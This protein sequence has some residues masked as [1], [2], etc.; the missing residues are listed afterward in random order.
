MGHAYNGPKSDSWSNK[1]TDL[2]Q[3]VN[4]KTLNNRIQRS[5]SSILYAIFIVFLR[6]L[7]NDL[8]LYQADM[9]ALET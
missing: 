9:L 1:C 8:L 5:I 3:E 7:Y 6:Q 2:R 4:K